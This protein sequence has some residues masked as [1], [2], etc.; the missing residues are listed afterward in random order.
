[1][2][3]MYP[4]CSLQFKKKSIA[5]I[6]LTSLMSRHRLRRAARAL[7]QY[8]RMDTCGTHLRSLVVNGRLIMTTA[9]LVRHSQETSPEVLQTLARMGG[10]C[11]R[12]LA[13]PGFQP[14]FT[15]VEGPTS[16]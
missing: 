11:L 7:S 2:D 10:I 5:A 12:G 6:F 4:F 8:G 15:R 3:P 14:K 1:M 13:G 16:L 9:V